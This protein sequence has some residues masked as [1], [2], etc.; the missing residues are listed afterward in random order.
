MRK[1]FIQKT[2][3]PV[4]NEHYEENA[5]YC[6]TGRYVGEWPDQYTQD[7][8]ILELDA[9]D[10]DSGE[11]VFRH[12]VDFEKEEY[13]TYPMEDLYTVPQ[14]GHRMYDIKAG[15]WTE[16]R[17]DTILEAQRRIEHGNH[18]YVPDWIKGELDG[19]FPESYRWYGSGTLSKLEG[20]ERTAQA[21]KAEHRSKVRLENIREMFAGLPDVDE[22]VQKWA[23]AEL[24]EHY[25]LMRK[26]DKGYRLTCTACRK[27]WNKKKRP[28]YGSMIACPY[29]IKWRKVTRKKEIYD[30][31]KVYKCEPFADG[32]IIRHFDIERGWE[33]VDGVWKWH[34][35][36]CEV[37]RGMINS[38]GHWTRS[39]YAI[40][41]SKDRGYTFADRKDWWMHTITGTGYLYP[42]DIYFPERTETD[43]M[44]YRLFAE[45]HYKSDWN[46]I[47]LRVHDIPEYTEYLYKSGLKRM[48]HYVVTA[49]CST[50]LMETFDDSARKL[51]DLLQLDSN[52]TARIKRMDIK[53]DTLQYL[54]KHPE[55]IS[56]QSIMLLDRI[57]AD[58]L[59][60]NETGLSITKAL[61]YIV[62]QTE[63]CGFQDSEETKQTYRDYI[64]MA[65]EN[66]EDPHDDIVRLCTNLRERHDA[67][68]TAKEQKDNRERFRKCKGVRKRYKPYRTIYGWADE[69]YTVIVPSK[70]EDIYREGREQHHCVGKLNY[71]ERHA[72][73]ETLIL[74]LRS[75]KKPKEPWYTLEVN[76]VDLFIKQKY[77]RYDRQPDLEIAD[78]EISKWK[79]EV[80]KRLKRPNKAVREA[81][82][83]LKAM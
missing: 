83:T 19:Q 40:G 82:E 78:A 35:A 10:N 65:I 53:I 48:A 58:N 57:G 15:K 68:A 74:F 6:F 52:M 71:M 8:N 23:E 51:P 28:K 44:M 79:K 42:E 43:L 12:F 16:A 59:M 22:E 60:L 4:P 45:D 29:C 25:V 64:T 32:G 46:G 75:A 62:R 2:F 33:Q 47:E 14:Y 81:L 73:G 3:D 49:T 21:H 63:K 11:L 61:N 41:Y 9:W 34:A 37:Q 76:P 13:W 5:R 26:T 72:A 30:K 70:P 36:V 20:W 7:Y 55:H 56:D 31:T 24:F 77:G 54:Q 67:L 69:E 39:F 27:G 50:E 80:R 38:H 66:G 18:D 17:I 1:A